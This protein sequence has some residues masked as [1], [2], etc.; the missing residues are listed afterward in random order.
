[1][2]FKTT[3]ALLVLAGAGVALY[4]V[5]GPSLPPRLDPAPKPPAA[6]DAGS[7]QVLEAIRPAEL[8]GI[9][10]RRG[11]RV[12]VLRR[13]PGGAWT[14]PG[15]WPTRSAEAQALA[16]LLGGLR[17][18]FE[19]LPLGD[20]DLKKYG[21]DRPA[22]VVKVET[23]NAKHTLAFGEG[24]AEGESNRFSRPTYVRVDDKPEALRLG[25]GLVAA[26]DRPS[27]YYL[28]RRLFPA[29]RVAKEG[30]ATEK[31]ERLLAK[32][33]TLDESKKDG[34]HCALAKKGDEWE[35]AA[36]ARD[37]LE[38]HARDALLAAVP[39]VW[40]ERFVNTD[41]SAAAAA[42]VPPAGPAALVAALFWTTPQGL[43]VKSGLAEPERTLAVTRDDGSTVTLLVGRSAGSR[44]RKVPAQAPP[45]LPPGMR[46]PDQTVLEEYRYAKLKDNEQIFEIKAD[47]LKDVFVAL[48]QLRDPQVARFSPA[49]A[50]RVELTHGAETI[51]LAKEKERWKF[52]KPLEA[53]ADAAKVNDVLDKLSA[54]QARDKDVIDKADPKKYGLD[55]PGTVVRV[56]VEEEVKGEKDA[57]AKN[58]KKK[59]RT[60][61]VRVGKHDT[62]AKKLYV[63]A[64]DLPRV[65]AVEDSLAPLLGRPA[66]AYR[67]KRVLDFAAADLAKVE[68]DR[69]GRKVALTQERGTWRLAAPFTA[70]ADTIKAE[71]VANGLGSL[72]ALEYVNDKPK[73]SDLEAQY[74]LGKPALKVTL[75]FTD[76][77]KPARTLLVGKA[78]GGKPGYFARLADAPAVFAVAADLHKQLDRDSLAYLPLHLWQVF[79]EDVES[80]RVRKGKEGEYRLT[81]K[82]GGWQVEGPFTA[83]ALPAT[84]QKLTNELS[85]PKAESYKAHDP[86]DLKPYGLDSPALSVTLKM[87][88]GAEHTL[89]I[90]GP[91]GSGAGRYARTEKGTSV[92][93]VS[94]ALVKAADHVAL[95][96]L[97]PALLNLDPAQVEQ[98]VSKAGD[99]ALKLQRQG[100]GWQVLDAPGAPFAADEAAVA[101]L[102]AVWRGLQAERF[103]AYGPKVEWARYGLDKPAAAV[104]TVRLKGEGAKPQTVEIGKPV[105]GESG[106][107]YAR[108][109]K[110]PGVAV[111]GA[112]PART[113]ARTYLDYVDHNVLKFDAGAVTQ[114]RRQM[115]PDALELA[116]RDDG[117]HLAKP[118]EQRGDDKAMQDLLGQ[119]GG[120]RAMRIAA[121]PARDLKEYGLDQPAAVVTVTLTADGKPAERVLKLGKVANPATGERFALA[122]GKAVA[123]LPGAVAK[124]LTA[125]PLAYRD[126]AL[127]RFAD[128]ERATLERGPR[129][130]TFSKEDGTWKLVEPLQAEADHDRLE[131]FIAALAKLRADELV[132]E[133][134]SAAQLKQYGL[135][136]PEAR[137]RLRAGDQ[138]VLDLAVGNREKGGPRCYARLAGRDLVFLL[139]PTLSARVLAE[140]RPQAVWS[141][142]LDAVQVVSLR[143]GQARNPFT[144]EK[145][146]GEAWQAAGKPD[147]KLN[148][149]TVNDTL[150]ALS[151]LKLERYAVDKD[152]DLKLFGLKEPELVLEAATRSG[153]RALQIG[154]FVGESKARYARLPD[155]PGVFVLDE[156]TASRL[157]RDLNA[158]TRPPQKELSNRRG[159][160][161]EKK[162]E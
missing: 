49:D 160:D 46:L 63:Q 151:G 12:T 158:F 64:D 34:L 60:L 71:Q 9:E 52:V 118:A 73:Q 146:E 103:A 68:I 82:A 159:T 51:V 74:G 148:E 69:N 56:T 110:G 65:N 120:L 123:V 59:T 109:N 32:G 128:A 18:R 47:G 107:R 19:P 37:R 85:A 6:T 45:N 124:R 102:E 58:K 97:D 108:V 26:I 90:G 100:K 113:L 98:V 139:D 30:S 4:L 62:E 28:Q 111:L 78:R 157:V 86:K 135:D 95:D 16:D 77:K 72:E 137:W 149:A 81:R 115:G 161:T 10:V 55:K 150:A 67:G 3:L 84:V 79:P 136:R 21:L 22:L 80:V 154:G 87:K 31:T 125:A 162:S 76:P 117:W 7:R 141:P 121:Y 131:D 20:G 25:P 36:P 23:D 1:M 53:D 33:V 143:Y 15:N 14:M 132:A 91:D 24:A 2:N 94:D 40:A 127:A 39:D 122:E 29:E 54:L 35:L 89:L 147:V 8:T 61:T 42:A 38:P 27:D 105:E 116:K 41:I 57:D 114:V 130:A 112:A 43:L 93:V 155:K 144:L 101:A 138:D 126:R 129:K 48:D 145:G 134:P 156:A 140:Y 133:K 70:D 66:L 75:T 99:T 88:G 17:T 50:R 152:G 96:L 83:A 11:D 13:K 5:G 106:A 92:F 153:K 104:V 119:L 142:P 44:A